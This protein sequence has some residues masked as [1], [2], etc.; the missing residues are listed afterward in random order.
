MKNPIVDINNNPKPIISVCGDDCSVC[1]RYTAKSEEELK[2]VAEFWY[3]AGWRDHV[4]TTEEIK[5]EGCST[6]SACGCRY[7]IL[8]CTIEHSVKK[9]PECKEFPCKKIAATL[10]ETD[11]MKAQCHKACETEEEFAVFERAFY[12]KAENFGLK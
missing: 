4:V 3:K 6:H 5:C 8:A 1:P 7:K 10:K 12:K 9:C 2:R 11:E